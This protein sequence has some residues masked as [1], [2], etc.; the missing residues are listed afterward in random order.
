MSSKSMDTQSKTKS[1]LLR[2]LY[3]CYNHFL[4]LIIEQF[5][6]W[7]IN[8]DIMITPTQIID[9]NETMRLALIWRKLGQMI[10]LFISPTLLQ[11]ERVMMGL[12]C[13]FT[14]SCLADK[15]KLITGRDS[16]KLRLSHS[17][18]GDDQ[19]YY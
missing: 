7:D 15:D 8:I 10:T 17:Y 16:R 2:V 6:N 1:N 13:L 12:S 14:Y 9:H 11:S 4:L 19:S 5:S 3:L 18:F